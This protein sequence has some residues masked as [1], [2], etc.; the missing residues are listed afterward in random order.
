[1]ILGVVA[2]LWGHH[3]PKEDELGDGELLAGLI[4]AW[5]AAAAATATAAWIT[6]LCL[7]FSVFSYKKGCTRSTLV[8]S[9]AS[10]Q[11]ALA[12]IWWNHQHDM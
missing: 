8:E 6:L 5:G 7:T 4:N 12:A 11:H 10:W 1:M 9:P 3:A 2:C